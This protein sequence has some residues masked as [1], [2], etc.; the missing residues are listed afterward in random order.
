MGLRR[1]K[2]QAYCFH[3]YNGQ[4]EPNWKVLLS[5]DEIIYQD[6]YNGGSW[7][8]LQD[9]CKEQKIWPIHMILEYYDNIINI[10]PPNAEGYFYRRGILVEMLCSAN[11]SDASPFQGKRGKTVVIGYLKDGLLYSTTIRIPEL[12]IWSTEIRDKEKME[13]DG[14]LKDKSLFLIN[15]CTQANIQAEKLGSLNM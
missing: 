11:P 3:L 5:N 1:S 7:S 2:D 13:K 10:L 14:I 9:Y 6:D 15:T 4:L 12:L 8:D